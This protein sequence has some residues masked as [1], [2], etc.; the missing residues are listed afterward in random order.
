MTKR[1]TVRAE[2]NHNKLTYFKRFR[3][4][5]NL[6]IEHKD[7]FGYGGKKADK[8]GWGETCDWQCR[9]L[10]GGELGGGGLQSFAKQ[11]YNTLK[12]GQCIT[13]PPSSLLRE[14]HAV[15][16]SSAQCRI[17]AAGILEG[18]A[19]PDGSRR[20][21]NFLGHQQCWSNNATQLNQHQ[22]SPPAWLGV[23]YF[24]AVF[25]HICHEI[26]VNWK[27]P[28]MPLN[29]HQ[30]SPPEKSHSNTFSV[31]LINSGIVQVSREY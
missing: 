15:Q 14:K 29:Q 2:T 18:W 26:H 11:D 9:E 19:L 24:P 16:L 23:A 6:M 10:G 17:Y 28:T 22:V 8:G 27:I 4:R 25:F 1:A 3:P 7:S 13:Q 20:A 30:V 5:K 21:G 12:A 31:K